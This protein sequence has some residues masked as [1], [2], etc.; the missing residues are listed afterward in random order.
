MEN[1][2]SA[3][4]VHRN[5]I[6]GEINHFLFRAGDTSTENPTRPYSASHLQT[7]NMI[8]PLIIQ[9]LRNRAAFYR[10]LFQRIEWDELRQAFESAAGDLSE[11]EQAIEEKVFTHSETPLLL[12]LQLDKWLKKDDIGVIRARRVI[13]VE[14]AFNEACALEQTGILLCVALEEAYPEFV[15][16][17]ASVK[18][19]HERAFLALYQLRDALEYHRMTVPKPISSSQD[20]GLP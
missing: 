7:M 3:L 16:D 6:L 11:P 17:W 13:S 15:S 10:E 5:A 12:A 18:T 9:L 14:N 20:S 4:T 8:H 2:K 19:V 1:S